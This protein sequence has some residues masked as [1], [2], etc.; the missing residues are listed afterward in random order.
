VK[1]LVKDSSGNPIPGAVVTVV[2]REDFTS[3]TT[4]RGEYWRL[5]LPGQYNLQVS[6]VSVI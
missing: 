6:T 2:D 4:P 3:T 5:L 1:G